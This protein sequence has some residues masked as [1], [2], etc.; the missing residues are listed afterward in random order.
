MNLSAP[1]KFARQIDK[2]DRFSF[3]LAYY[4]YVLSFHLIYAFPQMTATLKGKKFSCRAGTTDYFTVYDEYEPLGT[5]YALLKEGGFFLDIGANIGRYSLILA[6]RFEQVVAFEPVKSTRETLEKNRLLNGASN[7]VI[8]PA[9][10]SDKNGE[11]FISLDPSHMGGCTLERDYPK[12]ELIQTTTVDSCLE[13]LG[14]SP[15][16]VSLV[17]IDVET[18]EEKTLRGMERL[19][20]E[21]SPVL[22]VEIVTE[23]SFLEKRQEQLRKFGYEKM[24]N[25]DIGNYVFKKEGKK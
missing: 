8:I 19:L 11:A 13:K 14:I 3:L 22:I 18:H 16:D 15:T 1:F 4:L 7:L 12:K 9:A 25:L 5:E 6:D 10:A 23:P 17:K 2:K 24:L 20:T 21:G